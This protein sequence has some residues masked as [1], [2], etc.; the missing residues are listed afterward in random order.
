[1]LCAATLIV[2]LHQHR[3]ASRWQ[4]EAAA[5]RIVATQSAVAGRRAVRRERRMAIRYDRLVR[6]IAEHGQ[7][8]PGSVPVV[9][10][11]PAGG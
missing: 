5:W 6:S 3:E 4:R 10:S 7:H 1:M 2:A 11:A 9:G 8:R